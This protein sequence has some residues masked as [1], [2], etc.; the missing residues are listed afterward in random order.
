MDGQEVVAPTS[1][2]GAACARSS[3]TKTS[4]F[5]IGIDIRMGLQ[6]C[7]CFK[8]MKKLTSTLQ[9]GGSDCL[10]PAGP[11]AGAGDD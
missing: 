8:S 1:P 3:Q 7:Q 11:A 9:M 2:G 10:R 4:C 5:L 6:T